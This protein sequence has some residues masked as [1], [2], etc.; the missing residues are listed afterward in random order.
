MATT[1]TNHQA[2]QNWI[3]E[4]GGVP[5]TVESTAATPDGVG[6]LRVDFPY[7]GR[8]D[9]LSTISWE[10]FFAKFDEAEL[11]FLHEDETAEGEKSRFCKF[12]SRES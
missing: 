5:A 2:I 4:R 11:A 3:E 9:S 6:V 8:N 12:V 1:T 7:G 10:D